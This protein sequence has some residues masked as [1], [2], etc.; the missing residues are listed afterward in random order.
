[1]QGFFKAITGR[2]GRWVV[3]AIWLLAVVGFGAAQLP[4]KFEEVQNNES[5]SFLPGDAESTRALTDAETIRG[6]ESVTIV[7]V[8]RNPGGLTPANKARIAADR[9]ELD[10]LGLARTVI[11][12]RVPLTFERTSSTGPVIV[13]PSPLTAISAVRRAACPFFE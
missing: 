8:Y 7:A 9:R 4:S 12:S 3:V 2:R 1:M 6:E 11:P 13:S 10:S 5:T